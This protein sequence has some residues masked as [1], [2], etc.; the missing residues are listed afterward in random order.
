MNGKFECCK[1]GDE[2]NDRKYVGEIEN[3]VPRKWTKSGTKM[4]L[5]Q[6]NGF[7]VGLFWRNVVLERVMIPKSYE[8]KVHLG[9]RGE[10]I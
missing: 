4:E 1:N 6:T 2:Y 5:T 3:G 7:G 9:G 8:P 10:R